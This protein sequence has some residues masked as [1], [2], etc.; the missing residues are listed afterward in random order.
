MTRSARLS[1]VRL[2][3]PF[4]LAFGGTLAIHLILL[5]AGDA[6]VV[7][8]PPDPFVAPA[9]VIDVVDVLPPPPEKR[10]D[11]PPPPKQPE[12]IVE[13]KQE[14]KPV[15]K[16]QPTAPRTARA[17][18]Q[19]EQPN[20]NPNPSPDPGGEQTVQ[21]GD[22]VPTQDGLPVR[23]G[24]RNRT[25]GGGGKDGKGPGTGSGSGSGDPPPPPPVSL[26]LI[27]TPAMPKG[28]YGYI[29]AGRDYPEEARRLGIEGV[30]KVKLVVDATGKVQSAVL[31]KGLGHGLDQLAMT[32]ARQIKF[33]PAKDTEDRAVAS[34]VVWTFT[35]T[36][37]K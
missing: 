35:M 31:V 33:E 11:P 13:D 12:Q 17:Q 24:P 20:P 8:N 18:P 34:V 22:L 30:I 2:D 6:L 15:A 1:A 14:V 16:P 5:T 9:P 23:Q 3:S 10:P 7:T 4:S 36:L 21:L 26:A 27:K 25:G 19:P 28:D 32:R 37:P 29:D